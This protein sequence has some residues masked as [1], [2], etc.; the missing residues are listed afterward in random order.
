[1]QNDNQYLLDIKDLSVIY[2]LESERIKAVDKLSLQLAKEETLGV[3][4][5]SG[6]GKS[7]LALAIMGL[8]KAGEVKGEITYKGNDLTALSDKEFKRFRWQKIALVFQN[9]LEVFNPVLTIG[10]QIKEPLRTHYKLSAQELNKRV[11]K[12]LKLVGLSPKWS[13]QYPHNLSGGMRQRALLAMAL[14]CEPELLII[15]EP[16]TA[17]DPVSKEEILQLLEKLQNEFGFAM[18]MIS[19]DLTTIREFSSKVMTMYAGQV[20]ELGLSD[21]V[22]KEPCHP[23]TRGLLNSSPSL[24]KYKDLWGIEG[25]VSRGEGCLFSLRCPQSEKDCTNSK[26]S[27][28][29]IALERMVACHKGGIEKFL[30]AKE[31]TKSYKLKSE[32]VEAVKGVSLEIKSGEVV[33]LVGESGSGKSTLAHALAGIIKPDDGEV[34]YKGRAVKSNWA[35]KKVGGMQI[36]FQDASSATSSRMNVLDVVK[37]PLDII[38]WADKSKRE[39]RAVE[40]LQKVQLPSQDSFLTRYCDNLS[41]GQ[42]Q[43][44]AIARALVTEPELLIAD[45]ITSM[46][47]PSTQANLLRRLKGLQNRVG[48]AMLYI[49]HD[50]DLARKIADK[51]YVMQQGEIVES[52]AAFE[53]LENPSSN[54][55]K[56]LLNSACKGLV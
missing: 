17:L 14:S 40:C 47:D 28:K 30:E 55:T 20:V 48:F 34:Y 46:L 4:G 33:A 26:P 21:K 27:L 45:E 13:Q 32:K 23:Y 37:E 50:L 41:G 9:S 5:E 3:I 54:Y 56:R 1:M 44:V 19:H 42:R 7:S 29:Y 16:I 51:V 6:S 8:I 25:E 22:F 35:T 31:I 36:I 49:T 18:I 53:I 24:F 39:Q 2:Q 15:D 10:E 52:G 12:L 38:K 11:R 43:R